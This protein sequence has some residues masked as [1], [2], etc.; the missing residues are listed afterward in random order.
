MM[1]LLVFIGL[2]IKNFIAYNYLNVLKKNHFFYLLGFFVFFIAT[3][4][5]TSFFFK[6][7]NIQFLPVICSLDIIL[8]FFFSLLKIVAEYTNVHFYE[9]HLGKSN[10][11]MFIFEFNINFQYFYIVVTILQ[12][13]FCFLIL[14][15]TKELG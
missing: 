1:F 10:P 5:I 2:I 14:S 8:I 13:L 3:L 9:K 15:E 6:N 12:L 4:W 7:R 11:I